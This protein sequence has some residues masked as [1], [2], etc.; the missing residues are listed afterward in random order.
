M[1]EATD[2]A[3]AGRDDPDGSRKTAMAPTAFNRVSPR[4]GDDVV[5]STLFDSAS[6]WVNEG[7]AGGE[8]IR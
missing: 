3:T 4:S 5:G 8:V 2:F 7:G 6:V 1:N